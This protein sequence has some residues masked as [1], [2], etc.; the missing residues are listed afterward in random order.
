MSKRMDKDLKEVLQ[1]TFSI[2]E[3]K[4]LFA[5]MDKLNTESLPHPSLKAQ[6][7]SQVEREKPVTFS[8][9]RGALVF[10]CLALALFSFSSQKVAV[11]ERAVR[12]GENYAALLDAF[13][14]DLF[15]EEYLYFEDS[16]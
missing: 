9:I 4:E 13:G 16:L 15:A 12:S 11:P 6:I 2:S 8:F 7:L 10:C 5:D 3:Q 14:S 1:E